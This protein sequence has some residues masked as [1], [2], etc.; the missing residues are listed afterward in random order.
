MRPRSAA[1]VALTA[2]VFL[3]LAAAEAQEEVFKAGIELVDVSATVTDDDGRFINGLTK[4]DFIVSDNG[5][6]QEIVSFSSTRVPVSLAVLLDVSGSMTG[7]QLATAKLAINRFVFD[8]L[9]G[10]DELFL[11][12]FAGRG[13]ILQPWTQD[14][15]S[16]SRALARANGFSFERTG[17]AIGTVPPNF[18][19]AVYD[20]VA[21]SLG[22]AAKGMHRK[23]AVLVISDGVDTSSTRTVQQVQDAIRS[24]EILVYALRVDSGLAGGIDPRALRRL[25]DETG[26]RTEVVKG[27]KNLDEATA[28]LADEFNQQY[29]IGYTAPNRDGRWHTITVDV[30]RKGSHVRA[31]AGYTAS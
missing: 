9:G 6:P 19:T 10:D 26:G 11:M 7:D 25:T 21:A 15:E 24:S 14:R 29:L 20:A 18:G 5:K 31:R 4:D 28:R 23:K 17:D 30:R 1:V 3:A 12:Q 22:I 16:F 27:F 8:L 13:R 2:T